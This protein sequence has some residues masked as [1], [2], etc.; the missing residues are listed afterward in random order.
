MNNNPTLFERA[1]ARGQASFGL[2]GQPMGCVIKAYGDDFRPAFCGVAG[3]ELRCKDC[4]SRKYR[5]AHKAA[6][7]CKAVSR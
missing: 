4:W 3:S 2:D 6:S 1:K 5:E 7:T